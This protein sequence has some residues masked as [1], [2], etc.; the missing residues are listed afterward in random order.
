MGLRGAVIYYL[1]ATNR[2][3]M[4]DRLQNEHVDLYKGVVL[5]VGGR[6]RG[7]FKKPRD[8]VKRWIFADINKRYK[9]D[10]ILDVTDMRRQIKTGSVDVISAIELFEHVDEPEKG[11]AECRRVLRKGGVALISTPFMYPI[12]ADPYDYQRWTDSK[13]RRELLKVGFNDIDLQIM[14]RFFTI[15]ADSWR[16]FTISMPFGIRHVMYLLYPVLDIMTLLDKVKFI[17]ESALGKY[18]GGY[19]L[20]AR[21]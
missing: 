17:Q 4:L 5:D 16:I 18:H 1:W 20:I 2:R 10:V 14:G 13:W 8:K 9:P 11:I 3:K 19:F 15:A 21:K 7:N 12:H 6:D